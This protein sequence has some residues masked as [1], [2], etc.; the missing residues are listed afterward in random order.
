[1]H[2]ISVVGIGPGHPDYILPIVKKIIQDSDILIGGRRN[3]RSVNTRNK[4]IIHITS[5]LKKI[6]D[7]LKEN[8]KKK[9]ITVIVS[10]DCG[11]YSFL[12]YIKKNID[13]KLLHVVPGISSMQYM[14]SKIGES[15]DDA[16]IGSLHGREEDFIEELKIHNKVGLLTDKKWT[17]SRIAEELINNEMYDKTIYV[18]EN[19]SYENEKITQGTPKEISEIEN[20]NM[21]VVVIKDEK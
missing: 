4:E 11:Y 21:C 10:G 8:Y 16:Y 1:M 13:K 6:V 3:L 9:K 18:G 17:P 2:K 14:F 7:Y 12:K 5:D 20:F 19:L 15:W